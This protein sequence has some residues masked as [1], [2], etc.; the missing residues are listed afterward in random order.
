MFERLDHA[1][2]LAGNQ[3]EI[4]AVAIIGD[5]PESFDHAAIDGQ[6]AEAT[7]SGRLGLAAE[8]RK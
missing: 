5:M 4:I 8:A 7:A 2:S 1:R 6:L 3:I